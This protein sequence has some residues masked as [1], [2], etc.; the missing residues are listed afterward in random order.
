MEPAGTRGSRQHVKK[1]WTEVGFIN[2]SSYIYDMKKLDISKIELDLINELLKNKI[3]FKL[4]YDNDY[5]EE[6]ALLIIEIGDLKLCVDINYLIFSNEIP[7]LRFHNMNDLLN[8]LK[9]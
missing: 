1:V 8:Y 7:E 2:K 5:D 4:N 6:L 3:E 9:K